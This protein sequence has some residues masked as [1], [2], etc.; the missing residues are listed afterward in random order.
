MN[1]GLYLTGR[2]EGLARLYTKGLLCIF[3]RKGKSEN[4]T[5]KDNHKVFLEHYYIH[6]LMFKEY[7][8]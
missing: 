4:I 2:Y 5:S 7:K 3:Y 6:K 8:L 1:T